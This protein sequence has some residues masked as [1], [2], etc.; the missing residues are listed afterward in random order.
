MSWTTAQQG[1]EAHGLTLLTLEI[2]L[3]DP[4][5]LLPATGQYQHNRTIY[6]SD[7]KAK[8][9]S[10]GATSSTWYQA[11]V[12][13][14]GNLA[15][16]QE[17]GAFS[18]IGQASIVLNNK[19]LEW[20]EPGSSI[21]G[22]VPLLPEPVS[23]Q[24]RL[25][26]IFR[27]WRVKGAT[28]RL[29]LWVSEGN[30]FSLTG[31]PAPQSYTVATTNVNAVSLGRDT[32]TLDLLDDLS[33]ARSVAMGRELTAT[34][35]STFKGGNAPITMGNFRF[36]SYE[37]NGFSDRDAL[38]IG[39]KPRLAH[40]VPFERSGIDLRYIWHDPKGVNAGWTSQPA[41]GTGGAPASGDMILAYHADAELFSVFDEGTAKGQVEW[42]DDT[43]GGSNAEVYIEEHSY[44]VA[45]V[46]I[47]CQ[48]LD[49]A[50]AGK[51]G[52]N[53]ENM[54]DK[55]P[56]TF[57]SFLVNTVGDE[58]VFKIPPV[59]RYGEI[60]NTADNIVGWV[61]LSPSGPAGTP[62]LEMGLWRK[63]GTPDWV[64]GSPLTITT[65][66]INTRGVYVQ[67]M[68]IDTFGN[69][70]G[71]GDEP[72]L[73]WDWRYSDGSGNTDEMVLKIRVKTA[74]GGFDTVDIVAAGIAVTYRRVNEPTHTSI[75]TG[76]RRI[77][78]RSGGSFGG[79][80]KR[81]AKVPTPK[82]LI[83]SPIYP[84]P[85]KGALDDGSG[86]ITGT[87]DGTIEHALEC[88]RYMILTRTNGAATS[89]FTTGTTVFGSF[90]DAQT[91]MDDWV[92]NNVTGGGSLTWELNASS[93]SGSVASFV[94]D[95]A[96]ESPCRVMRHPSTGKY[97]AVSHIDG[98]PG[99]RTRFKDS[100]G[101][102]VSFHPNYTPSNQGIHG[103]PYGCVAYR[104][105]T[106][107][108]DEIVTD[109]RVRFRR[110]APTGAYLDEVHCNPDEQ[111]VWNHTTGAYVTASSGTL[112]TRC[113]SAQDITGKRTEEVVIESSYI[114]HPA[115]ATA[116]LFY[117]TKTRTEERVWVELTTGL[118]AVSCVPGHVIA[119]D[120]DFNLVMPM[121]KYGGDDWSDARFMVTRVE[122]TLGAGGPFVTITAE[123]HL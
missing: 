56:Y 99:P 86:S 96:S 116:L 67:T 39:V 77:G 84:M 24:I 92:Q 115:V 91:D 57:G 70:P 113:S 97:Y 55:D 27:F 65:T 114:T 103:K 46:D 88:A 44:Q 38:R 83:F 74:G 98:T 118:E 102:A 23:Y 64:G 40:A 4:S 2:D 42:V 89:D 18:T 37:V 5:N 68:P 75:G 8:R 66:D 123:E 26:E 3:T 52:S 34:F 20:Q 33:D 119:L 122:Q 107:P 105:G 50:T 6:L 31:T 22:L 53:E 21:S 17:A 85:S 109:F 13:D 29:V 106:T 100:A 19:R 32:I 110:F 104:C 49:S 14:W 25:S 81:F 80:S 121:P 45:T 43:V 54:Y 63:A 61:A 16:A 7:R 10:V 72:A 76:G 69:R 93:N 120:N 94:D 78:S 95:L 101:T 51:L 62:A 90:D 73:F 35:D 30:G 41:Y 9:T 108:L 58:I 47:Q 1:L 59:G 15:V 111:K 82:M 60:I 79:V 112:V 12:Q 48:D 36:R 11:A 71:V 117:L 28:A 87:P